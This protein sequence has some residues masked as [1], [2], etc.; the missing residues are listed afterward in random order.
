MRNFEAITRVIPI[1]EEN[2]FMKFMEVVTSCIFSVCWNCCYWKLIQDG[3]NNIIFLYLKNVQYKGICGREN[4]PDI[5]F[6][7]RRWVVV[8][9]HIVIFII[10][11]ISIIIISSSS[12]V[13]C[14]TCIVH[15]VLIKRSGFLMREKYLKK[16]FKC[17]FIYVYCYLYWI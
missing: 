4:G 15:S 7:I 17:H 3:I 2:K 14:N 12:S 1:W 6:N 9:L 8:T 16:S 5:A 13:T 10:I 11:F